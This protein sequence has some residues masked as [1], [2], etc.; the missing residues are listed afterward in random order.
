M[1]KI[2]KIVLHMEDW[3]AHYPTGATIYA[4]DGVMIDSEFCDNAKEYIEFLARYKER[5]RKDKPVIQVDFDID[6]LEEST[7]MDCVKEV[8]HYLDK[9]RRYS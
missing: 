2:G 7:V 3:T 6:D 8:K 1:E 9:I 5:I 4:V